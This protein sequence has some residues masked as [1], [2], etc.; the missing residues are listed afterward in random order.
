MNKAD[1]INDQNSIEEIVCKAMDKLKP[2]PLQNHISSILISLTMIPKD[3]PIPQE[4]QTSHILKARVKGMTFNF[5]DN[6]PI[7]LL[8]LVCQ[9]PGLGM[10]YLA[11]IQYKCKQLNLKTVSLE[12]LCSKL[13]P[14]GFFD[15][16]DL[17]KIWDLQKVERFDV[18]DSDNLIDYSSA[19]KSIQFTD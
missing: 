1:K 12:D 10:L 19:S 11:Y 4:I 8:G 6:K 5:V 14:D 9:S 16:L 18:F 15:H 7:I 13:F 2:K 3:V 17:L